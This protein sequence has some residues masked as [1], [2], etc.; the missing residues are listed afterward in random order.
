MCRRPHSPGQQSLPRVPPQ[1]QE[2]SGSPE[3]YCANLS[4]H[5]FPMATGKTAANLLLTEVPGVVSVA[6]TGRR[7]EVPGRGQGR[8]SLRSYG[9][10]EAA[11]RSGRMERAMEMDGGGDHTAA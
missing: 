6:E 4:V 8:G 7:L 10:T 2:G 9:L 1:V 11:F 5:S 3:L